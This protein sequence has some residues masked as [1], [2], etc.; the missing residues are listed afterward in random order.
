MKSSSQVA[1]VSVSGCF[2]FTLSR[3]GQES[4]A[5]G[6]L[7]GCPESVETD[8]DVRDVTSTVAQEPKSR[9]QVCV[10]QAGRSL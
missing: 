1:P 2:V 6:L 7:F 3:A 9:R 8:S 4:L 5:R 10:Q